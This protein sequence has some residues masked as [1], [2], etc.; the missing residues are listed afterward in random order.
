MV[1]QAL[2][3]LR[4][5]APTNVLMIDPHLPDWLPDLRLKGLRVGG[6][7]VDLHVW[8][9]R[10][11]T[12]WDAQVRSGRLHVTQRPALRDPRARTARALERLISG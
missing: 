7:V 8:R 5:F 11:H 6:A 9:H 12:K 1:I 10:E 3:G 2:L 4:P